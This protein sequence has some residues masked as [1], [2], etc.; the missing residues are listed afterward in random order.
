MTQR[1]V[2]NLNLNLILQTTLAKGRIFFRGIFNYMRKGE[3]MTKINEKRKANPEI[4]KRG[5]ETGN[6]TGISTNFVY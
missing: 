4:K 2:M 6:F 1:Q 3:K 5:E